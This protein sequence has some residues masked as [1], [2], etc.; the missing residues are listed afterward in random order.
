MTGTAQ[1]QDLLSLDDAISA[2]VANNFSYRIAE[3][4]PQ[5]SMESLTGQEAV[6]DSEIFATGNVAQSQQTT[7]FTEGLGTTVVTSD[8]RNW[9]AGIRKRLVHGTLVTAQTTLNRRDSEVYDLNQ[10]S[11][12]SISIRQPLMNGFGREANTVGIELAKAGLKASSASFK[13]TIQDVL[14]QVEL[15]YWLVSRWQ[16]QLELN[17][18]KLIVSE[19][20][21]LEAQERE[22]VGMV[23]QIEVLQAQAFN[24]ESKE[25][26][27]ATTRSLGD[28]FDRLLTLMGTLPQIDFT[29][30]PNNSVEALSESD[31]PV[32]DFKI[33]WELAVQTDPSLTAQSA[34]IEQRKMELLSAHYA[35]RPNLD[36][37][38]SGGYTGSD[39]QT[40]T[41]AYKNT[42]DRDGK[43]WSV[44]LEFS[45]P[46][47]RRKEKSD[48][49]IADLRME[50]EELRY[51]ELKQSLYQDVRSSWRAL[52]A[53]QQS[54]E[55][56]NLTV[57][58]QE[59]SFQRE[60]EKYASGLSAFRDVLEAQRDLDQAQVRLL[61]SKYNKI[62]AEINLANLTGTIFARHGISPDLPTPN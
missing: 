41:E 10:S 30:A 38:V 25:D 17:K 11:D 20:L 53:V 14:A 40:A 39:S 22:R 15:A 32:P 28:A 6:F 50:R 3:L 27:I 18:S 57:N 52:Q 59:A 49:R 45:M 16:E 60:R 55:A 2:A 9:R 8:N 7:A 4:D 58:L 23:T 24:A 13:Q 12:I 33:A 26:I 47:S 31:Y 19:T 56:A 44:G 51:E 1:Q 35:A 37:V 36:L 46:W 21:L 62:S 54:L 42:F 61:L 29:M 5:I 34:V 48:M 43:A